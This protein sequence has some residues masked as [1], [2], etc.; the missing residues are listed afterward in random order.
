MTKPTFRGDPLDGLAVG[1][2]REDFRPRLLQGFVQVLHKQRGQ[3]VDRFVS[4]QAVGRQPIQRPPHRQL[5]AQS[6]LILDDAVGDGVDV[7]IRQ[8]N[9]GAPMIILRLPKALTFVERKPFRGIGSHV[10]VVFV[11]DVDDA[12]VRFFDSVELILNAFKVKSA[13]AEPSAQEVQTPPDLGGD[14]V[15]PGT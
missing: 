8:Q 12:V 2:Y 15:G 10:R 5:V 4:I 6:D 11:L 13:V 1:V 9:A 14:S 3:G 7:F